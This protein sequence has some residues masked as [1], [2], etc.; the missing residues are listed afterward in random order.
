MVVFAAQRDHK[1]TPT[2]RQDKRTRALRAFQ[3]SETGLL[4]A[5]LRSKAI[6]GKV[7]TPEGPRP[8]TPSTSPSRSKR[9]WESD[10]YQYKT[11]SRRWA[12]WGG[13]YGI[14]DPPTKIAIGEDPLSQLQPSL[15]TS[16]T[17]HSSGTGTATVARAGSEC[18][19]H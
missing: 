13:K 9:E 4:M 17:A 19:I 10:F 7:Q 1:L 6:A 12:D 8:E 5:S 18:P 3:V 11:L 14:C 2:S 15:Q 16:E